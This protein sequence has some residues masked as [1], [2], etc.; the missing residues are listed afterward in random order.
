VLGIFLICSGP[1]RFEIFTLL[2][3]RIQVI[4][5]F[6]L[7]S[8]VIDSECFDGTYCLPNVAVCDLLR[9]TGYH[10]EILLENNAS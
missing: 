7:S 10:F 3:L 4:W 5:V 8:R 6:M 1:I 9:N 2:I